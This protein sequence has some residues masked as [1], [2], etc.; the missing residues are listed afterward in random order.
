MLV[1][2]YDFLC[3][4]D[5]TSLPPLYRYPLSIAWLRVRVARYTHPVYSPS[6]SYHS[7]VTSL[8]PLSRYPLSIAWLRVRVARYTFLFSLAWPWRM[9]SLVKHNMLK[10]AVSILALLLQSCFCCYYFK[11]QRWRYCVLQFAYL[12][13]RLRSQV[14]WVR[15]KYTHVC[16]SDS[17]ILRYEPQ[18]IIKVETLY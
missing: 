16:N 7:D 6:G 13:Y 2:W 17:V 4:S 9:K 8:P 1:T 15:F 18:N 11:A 3:H 14:S 5:M 10:V 12:F